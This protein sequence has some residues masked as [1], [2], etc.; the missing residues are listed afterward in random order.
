LIR[1]GDNIN[2]YNRNEIIK[3]YN[4]KKTLYAS[5]KLFNDLDILKLKNEEDLF[6]SAIDTGK[7]TFVL[8]PQTKEKFF[9]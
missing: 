7:N 6:F 5:E 3:Y 8:V 9:S 2:G 1:I 4:E